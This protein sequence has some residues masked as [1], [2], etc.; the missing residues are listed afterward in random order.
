MAPA[1]EGARQG[2]E[3]ERVRREGPRRGR[4]PRA[5]APAV[6]PLAASFRWRKTLRLS[7]WQIVFL[8]P[9]T[10]RRLP[11]P[12]KEAKADFDCSAVAGP[13]PGL[14][15]PGSRGTEA[16]RA[17]RSCFAKCVSEIVEGHPE[18]VKG[19][20][21]VLFCFAPPAGPIWEQRWKGSGSGL[22]RARRAARDF[23]TNQDPLN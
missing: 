15:A 12:V 19:C 9:P 17:L 14:G 21:F 8:P 7:V 13:T 20:L 3:W 11:R 22:W 23:G 6:A 16:A 5:A 10:P 1:G 2:R 18:R 4:G